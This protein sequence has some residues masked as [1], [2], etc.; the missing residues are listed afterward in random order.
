VLSRGGGAIEGWVTGLLGASDHALWLA[1][2]KLLRREPALLALRPET[3]AG[4]VDAVRGL[5]GERLGM[6]DRA[7]RQAVLANPGLLRMDPEALAGRG[8]RLAAAVRARRGMSDADMSL[9][10]AAVFRTPGVAAL[11]PSSVEAKL[12]AYEEAFEEPRG[13]LARGG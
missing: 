1:P 12:R 11:R 3:V 5:L 8:E 7:A 9:F 4:K 6:G 13:P 2:E 10:L